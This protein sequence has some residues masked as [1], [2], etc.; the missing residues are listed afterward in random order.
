M[1]P[2]GSPGID[3]FGALELAN[4]GTLRTAKCK[5]AE[6][7]TLQEAQSLGPSIWASWFRVWGNTILGLY[8]ELLNSLV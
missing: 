2:Y 6:S 8:K 1:E 3:P 4:Q 5:L 7:A